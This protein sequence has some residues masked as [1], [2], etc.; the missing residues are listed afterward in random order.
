MQ[1]RPTITFGKLQLPQPKK[2]KDAPPIALGA[3]AFLENVSIVSTRQ[4][5]YGADD[6]IIFPV[7]GEK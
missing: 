4:R 6:L 3:R 7:P 5:I 1:G 2:P